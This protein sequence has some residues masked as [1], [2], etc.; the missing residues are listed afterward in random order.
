MRRIHSGV[1]LVSTLPSFYHTLYISGDVG[2]ALGLF[3][4][5]SLLTIIEMIY[6]CIKHGICSRKTA[7]D[8]ISWY[9]TQINQTKGRYY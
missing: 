7:N 1:L 5:A 6:L 4:G 2:G 9:Y 3:V 8:A